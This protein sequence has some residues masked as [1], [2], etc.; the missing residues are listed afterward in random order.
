M[1]PFVCYPFTYKLDLSN[2]LS[3]PVS[4]HRNR[5]L[6][7]SYFNIKRR[8]GLHSEFAPRLIG[9]AGPNHYTALAL[10]I[11]SLLA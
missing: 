9:I 1:Q 11:L 10:P 6:Y 2:K 8:K 3:R 5:G 7:I 4:Q